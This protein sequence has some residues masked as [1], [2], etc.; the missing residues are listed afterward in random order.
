MTEK[1]C[2]KCK[3]VTDEKTCPNCGGSSFS[4]DWTGYVVI[5]DPSG[6]EIAQRLGVSKPGRYALKVR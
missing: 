3:L 2:R 5:L 1:V 4:T 6:S